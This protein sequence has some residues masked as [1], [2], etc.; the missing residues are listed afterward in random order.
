MAGSPGSE[1][2]REE[3]GRPAGGGRPDPAARRRR[4]GGSAQ[5]EWSSLSPLGREKSALGGSSSG[6]SPSNATTLRRGETAH[7]AVDDAGG[8]R[9]RRRAPKRQSAPR[10]LRT[11]RAQAPE[12]LVARTGEAARRDH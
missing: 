7:P 1:G 2:W 8:D 6:G 3:T 11:D 4:G 9:L 12:S 10:R 5:S